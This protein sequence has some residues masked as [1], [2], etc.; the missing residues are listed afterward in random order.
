MWR[1]EETWPD[2]SAHPSVDRSSPHTITLVETS[3]SAPPA[4][5][6]DAVFYQIFP[7]RFARSG[8]V[9]VGARLEPWDSPPTVTGYKGGDLWG[10]VQKLDYLAD[11]GV[12][13]LWL[14]PIFQSASNHRYHTHD[15]FTIDPLLGGQAAFEAL[16][17]EAHVRDMK[18]ILDGVFNHASRGFFQFSDIA[19]HQSKSAYVDWFRVNDFPIEPYS[20]DTPASYA[21]WWGLHALPEFNTDNEVVREFLWS[22]GEHWMRQG[23]DGWRLDVPNEI[24][25]PGFWEEFRKRVRAINPDAYLVG[26]LWTEAAD[27]VGESNRFDGVMNYPLTTAII[28]FAIGNRID[29]DAVINNNEYEISDGIHAAEFADRIDALAELYDG[30]ERL[31]MLNLLDS[32]DTARIGTIANDEPELVR[33]ALALLLTMPGAPC[34]YYGTEVGMTG[35]PDP[36]CR[37]GFPLDESTWNTDTLA[38]VRSLLELRHAEPALRS[39]EIRRVGPPVGWTSGRTWVCERGPGDNALLVAVNHA[40]EADVVPL[41]HKLNGSALG[42]DAT[43]HDAEDGCELHMPPR[44][45]GVWRIKGSS[46]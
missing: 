34:L 40:D 42:G 28:S 8:R 45:F 32:H 39:H 22:V 24:S 2:C 19:E 17:S 4:W 38:L 21:A 23:I 31:A 46:G 44:S 25:T 10:V 36:G 3:L 37:E 13:A 6:A 15:Y 14:N 1:T 16:V 5:V 20:E 27:W 29:P 41:G 7:D 12:T 30:P 26:E 11:L 33:L 35:G 18:V 43:V 9:D